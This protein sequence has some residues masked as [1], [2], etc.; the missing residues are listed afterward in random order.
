MALR[1]LPAGVFHA[2]WDRG[3]GESI[4]SAPGFGFDDNPHAV[5]V[6]GFG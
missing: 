3:F 6:A 2:V 5:G 1:S 4:G